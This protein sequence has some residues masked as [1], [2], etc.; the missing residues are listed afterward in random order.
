[1]SCEVSEI[2]QR[3]H[4]DLSNSMSLR[5][6]IK[7]TAATFIKIENGQNTLRDSI[8]SIYKRNKSSLPDD[9]VAALRRAKY[10]TRTQPSAGSSAS[11]PSP[12]AS[13]VGGASSQ[14]TLNEG[15]K[16]GK[17]VF[18][19]TIILEMPQFGESYTSLGSKLSFKA[20]LRIFLLLPNRAATSWM[21]PWER[22]QMQG[23]GGLRTWEK[24]YWG[25]FVVA[26]SL[27]LFNRLRD[28]QPEEPQV[29]E[30]KETLKREKA[31]MVLAGGS[32]VNFSYAGDE[33]EE[34]PFEG[35][36][37]QEVQQY[38]EETTGASAKDPFEGMS[39]EEINEYMRLQSEGN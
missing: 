12:A 29:D 32:V 26:I 27:F 28:V 20:V 30:K 14:Q 21:F 25:V 22:R 7:E 6:I 34:D 15:A 38:V 36:S 16:I 35:L 2:S 17:F 18:Q 11:S 33:E 4:I 24:M 37:P 39:P 23:S 9:I 8:F 13:Q 5:K 3:I 19:R 10:P 31:R 1:M